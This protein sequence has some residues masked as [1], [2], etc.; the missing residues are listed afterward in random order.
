M[1]TTVLPL[2]TVADLDAHRAFVATLGPKA[3]GLDYLSEDDGTTR[4]SA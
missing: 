4:A 3:I 2:L 1:S